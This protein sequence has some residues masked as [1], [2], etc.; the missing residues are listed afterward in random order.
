MSKDRE[1]DRPVS[2]SGDSD[3]QEAV[4]AT[5]GETEM[6]PASPARDNEDPC[7]VGQTASMLGTK[8]SNNSANHPGTGR[9]DAMDSGAILKPCLDS[10]GVLPP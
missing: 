8:E 3:V 5:S 6:C 7:S 9:D 4:V 10:C 2:R 1:F